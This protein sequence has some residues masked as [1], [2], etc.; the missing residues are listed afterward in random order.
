FGRIA[1]TNALSNIYTINSQPVSTLNLV[2]F[3]LE[4]LGGDVLAKILRGKTDAI[5]EAS[6]S[7]VNS[8]SIDDAEPKY[9][10][11]V[12]GIVHPD[13]VLHNSGGRAKNML[14]LTKPLNAGTVATAVKRGLAASELVERAVDVMS[15]LNAHAGRQAREA[16]T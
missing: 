16:G 1:A 10:L 11:A 4:T 6:A 7:I 12:T 15:E 2:A 13:L 9:G 14:V 3:P 8:H 5:A